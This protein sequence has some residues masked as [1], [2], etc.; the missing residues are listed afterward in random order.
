[1]MIFTW[2]RLPPLAGA[3]V[4]TVMAGC[5]SSPESM[6]KPSTEAITAAAAKPMAAAPMVASTPV[7]YFAVLPENER[8]YLFND[9]KV[10]STY[11]EHEEV[12]LTRSRIG[13]SPAGTTV[14]F[15][16]TEADVKA[17]APTVA[18]QLFDG[19]LVPGKDFYGE[20]FKDG[21]F[22]I[23]GDFADMKA[24]LEHGEVAYAFTDIGTGPNGASLV[25]VLNK[26]S[27]KLGRPKQTMDMFAALR[28]G[29]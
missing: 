23:F 28:S 26:D 16:I 13:A 10:Y 1:M 2:R 7:R 6:N 22:Y 27:I 14:V 21:R 17:A 25:W 4:L 15:G 9:H 11:L 20:V 19:K 3:L 5:A 29:K 12:A 24:F 18:E 8:H